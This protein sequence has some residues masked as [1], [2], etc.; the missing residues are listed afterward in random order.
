MLQPM[1]THGVLKALG[2]AVTRS[3]NRGQL[4]ILIYHRVLPEPDLMLHDEIDENVF[5]IHMDALATGFNMLPLSEAVE[6]LRAGTLPTRAACITFD[7]GYANNITVALPI[8]Q[9]RSL[10]ACFFIATEFL[11][12]GCMW[13]DIVIESFRKTQKSLVDLREVGLDIYSLD[14]IDDRPSVMR[15]LLTKLKRLNPDLRTAAVDRLLAESDVRRPEGLMMTPAQV[16]SLVSAG[17]EIGGHTISHPIL[18]TLN[19]KQARAEIEG[20]RERLAA[21]TG[22]PVKLFAYPNGRPG[23]DFTKEHVALLRELEF[24][25]AVTTANGTA[26][27]DTDP[28]L[29]PRFTPWDRTETRFTLRLYQNALFNKGSRI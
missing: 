21:I 14:G 27:F 25:A 3:G 2:S 9:E 20:G 10:P 18:S 23:Q 1:I 16:R 28:L 13:N 5:R 19:A 26:G 8:L 11:D 4:S 12:G 22:K 17:M 24:D 15:K 6:R 29:L 7:D